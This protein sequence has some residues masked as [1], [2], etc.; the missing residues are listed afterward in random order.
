MPGTKIISSTTTR[1]KRVGRVSPRTLVFSRS[2]HRHYS[3]FVKQNLQKK[4]K[5]QVQYKTKDTGL[6]ADL[7]TSKM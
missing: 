1:W 3:T 2:V 7:V 4:E 5:L 6:N